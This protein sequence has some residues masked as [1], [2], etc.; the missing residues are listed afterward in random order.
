MGD[1]V[2]RRSSR[3]KV[4]VPDSDWPS[5][6]PPDDLPLPWT[7]H[8][9]MLDEQGHDVALAT[10][11]TYDAGVSCLTQHIQDVPLQVST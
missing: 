11:T 2:S 10:A 5:S 6:S 3:Q 7:H 4:N 8:Q 9:A 1:C